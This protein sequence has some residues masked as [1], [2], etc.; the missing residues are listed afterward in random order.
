MYV[1]INKIS[2]LKRRLEIAR[3]I[4][5]YK[6]DYLNC[7][8]ECLHL[9]FHNYQQHEMLEFFEDYLTSPL[10]Y[11]IEILEKEIRKLQFESFIVIQAALFEPPSDPVEFC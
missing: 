11:N 3:T 8:P 4:E 2:E 9:L 7:R 10:K 5:K 1:L 6:T